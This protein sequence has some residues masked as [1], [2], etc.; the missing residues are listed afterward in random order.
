MRQLARA[1]DPGAAVV[2]TER[3]D[4]MPIVA[5]SNPDG[6][7]GVFGHNDSSESVTVELVVDDVAPL[8][9]VLDPWAVFSV[10]G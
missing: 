3:I 9:F 6:T 7:V 4:S 10:R 1:G 5:F 2:P 8:R